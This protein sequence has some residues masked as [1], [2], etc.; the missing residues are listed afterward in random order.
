MAR[1]HW[2]ALLVTMLFAACDG[3]E[4]YVRIP[5]LG[6]DAGPEPDPTADAATEAEASGGSTATGTAGAPAPIATGGVGD[7]G[8]TASGG[9]GTGGAAAAATGGATTTGG[10]AG[11]SDA[12]A[13]ATGGRAMV[14]TGG[15]GGT[16]GTSGTGT[17]PGTGGSNR[18]GTGGSAIGTGGAATGGEAGG[19]GGT[20][21]GT[22]GAAGTAGAGGQSDTS[23]SDPA[24]YHFES[25]T[26]GW[27]NEA[28]STPFT[29]VQRTS[30]VH[31]AGKNA[32]A[33]TITEPKSN[34]YYL[35]VT[36]ATAVPAGTTVTFHFQIPTDAALTSVQPYVKGGSPDFRWTGNMIPIAD[37]TPNVWKTV[38]VR[39]S[40]NADPA[41]EVGVQFNVASA[42]TGTVYVD[43][44]DW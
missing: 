36:P 27:S 8:A 21:V 44:V 18:R 24:R 2:C 10:A 31:F 20:A 32:L 4:T 11:A 13:I 23:A 14:G 39:L 37:I 1:K 6:N 22:G 28:G 33:A 30:T 3:P 38:T 40:N 9:A 26:Q 17:S 42:W 5:V 29:S 7:V 25:W 35:S 12:G 19:K 43:S 16:A 41:V 15:A 34:R